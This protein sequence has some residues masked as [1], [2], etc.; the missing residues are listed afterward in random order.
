MIYKSNVL[1]QL[2]K[3][4]RKTNQITDYPNISIENLIIRSSNTNLLLL[5]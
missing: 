5:L 1:I 4:N 2:S 3:P